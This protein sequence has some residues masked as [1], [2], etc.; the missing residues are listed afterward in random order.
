MS[1]KSST[2]SIAKQVS[3]FGGASRT[4]STT[5]WIQLLSWTSRQLAN[6]TAAAPT[7]LLAS[8]HVEAHG[9]A[10]AHTVSVDA[11]QVTSTS[12][13]FTALL[14]RIAFHHVIDLLPD[15]EL[16]ALIQVFAEQRS[17]RE[18]ALRTGL[19]RRGPIR[20]AQ[21]GQTEIEFHLDPD[22][23]DL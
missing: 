17:V 9:K 8:W 1:S 13:D 15:H 3:F 16:P 22:E 18:L 20:V 23:L 4:N 11:A 7:C 19:L 21:T 6:E 5:P 14:F 10:L 2:D 12:P